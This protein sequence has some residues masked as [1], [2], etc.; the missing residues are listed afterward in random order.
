MRH[1]AV[2]LAGSDPSGGAGIQADIKTFLANGVYGMA[3]PTALTAQNTMG[4]TGI[5]EVPVDFLEKQM[6]AVFSDIPPE[7]VKI[8][9]LHSKEQAEMISVKLEQYSAKNV[10]FDPVMI[11]SS[12]KKLMEDEVLK[13][14]KE[15]LFPKL[16]LLTPNL[17]EVKA[18]CGIEIKTDAD[19]QAAAW[20]I[21]QAYGCGVLIKGGHR[22]GAADDLLCQNGC[23]LWFRGERI[24]NANNHGTGC[25][26][27]SAIAANLAKGES[28][29]TAVENAKRYLSE[30][31]AAMLDLG[32]GSGPLDHGC[33]IMESDIE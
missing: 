24:A 19:A 27:S 20:K 16:T 21:E 31:L 29:T 3:I 4:V 25:T 33:R 32:K 13:Q 10:V 18:I 12:G 15:T 17:L 28:L 5:L 9:M 8:G 14:I 1:T 2:S 30:T 23:F 11:S 7:A 6:D 26:L 22:Q